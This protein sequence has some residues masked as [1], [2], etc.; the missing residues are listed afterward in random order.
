MLRSHEYQ[1]ISRSLDT[2]YSMEPVRLKED[3]PECYG[4]LPGAPPVLAVSAGHSHTVINSGTEQ[5]ESTNG[6]LASHSI[7][8]PRLS[9]VA[10]SDSFRAD[11]NTETNLPIKN[12]QVKGQ[13]LLILC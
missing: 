8:R 1:T 5:R 10:S 9:P 13:L 7:D 11:E 2:L 4:Y 12:Q 3:D 6:S